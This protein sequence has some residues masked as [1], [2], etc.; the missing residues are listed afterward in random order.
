MASH[1]QMQKKTQERGGTSHSAPTPA[2][3]HQRQALCPAR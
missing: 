1:T 3:W 2:E